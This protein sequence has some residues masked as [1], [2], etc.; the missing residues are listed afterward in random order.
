[1]LRSDWLEL[2][3]DECETQNIQNTCGDL[4]ADFESLGPNKACTE[5]H[6]I[7]DND[8]IEEF[9]APKAAASV[10]ISDILPVESIV[11]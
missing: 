11:I 1:M 3:L 2:V 7:K 5:I 8:E 6:N 10:Q 9:D 4:D